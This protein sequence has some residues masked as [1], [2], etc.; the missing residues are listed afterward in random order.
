M[1]PVDGA[2][3]TA[4]PDAEAQRRT[5]RRTLWLTL[6]SLAVLVTLIVLLTPVSDDSGDTRLTTRQYGPGNA[7]LASDLLRRLGWRTRVLDQPLRAPLDTTVTYAVFAGPTLMRA[8]EQGALLAAV[9]RGAGLL[10]SKAEGERFTLLDSLGLR[11]RAAGTVEVHP[12]GTCPVETD[13]LAPLR[14]RPRMMTFDTSQ[15][16]ARKGSTVVPYPREATPLLSSA[17]VHRGDFEDEDEEAGTDSAATD[18]GAPGARSPMAKPT[19]DTATARALVA[20]TPIARNDTTLLPTMLAFP[21]GAGRVVALADPDVLRTD[22][23]RNCASGDA[24]AVVRAAEYLSPDRAREIVFVEYYQGDTGDG[25]MVV[26]GEWL[27]GTGLGRAVLTLLAA[28]VVLLVARGRRTLAPVYVARQE[29]RSALE[30]VDAL[31][32]A[33]RAVRGTRT[34]ARMLA[35]GIRRRHAAG[36][37]RM[38][39]DAA[40]LAALA[41]RH[42][43][44]APQAAQLT[45]ALTT[46]IAPGDLATLRRAAAQI[47]AE[48]VAP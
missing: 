22:Q 31:A 2:A 45:G 17:V 38:L 5:G 48:C 18:S 42:P 29:R 19:G 3:L 11:T 40:F 39:D 10:V 41:E 34:V 20:P 15:V 46:P 44:I 32:T 16:V 43:A 25:P 36:R 4:A 14:V 9:R 37:W 1:A 24:L 6:A 21:L 13:P 47:D 35:R 12:L 30:H 28:C 33:W 23:V 8:P 26:L 7:K 27:R